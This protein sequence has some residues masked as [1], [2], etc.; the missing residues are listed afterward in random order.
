MNIKDFCKE[1]LSEIQ[2]RILKQ[3]YGDTLFAYC[4]IV[5]PELVLL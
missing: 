5:H 4:R 1:N 3:L 2:L